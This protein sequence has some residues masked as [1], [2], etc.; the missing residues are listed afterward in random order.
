[1][2]IYNDLT[3]AQKKFVSHV[4][5]WGS[6][7]AA[8][9]VLMVAFYYGS[10]AVKNYQSVRDNGTFPLSVSG[11]GTVYASPDVATVNLTVR[12]QAPLIKDASSDNNKKNNQLVAFL[13]S[14]SVDTK[15]IKT[16]SY[17]VTPQY[18]YDNRPCPLDS[19][20]P[21]PAQLPPKIVGY[22]VSN[23]VEVKVRNLDMVGAILDGAVSAGAN[24]ISGPN[25][26]V[27][28]PD[29]AKDEARAL[30]LNQAKAK[31]ETLAGAM[32]VRLIKISGF[33]ESG[34]TPIY[35]GLGKGMSADIAATPAAPPTIEPGQNEVKVTVVVTYDAK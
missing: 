32:G 14:K 19:R 29:K 13:K 7:G 26:M 23:S 4:F 20:V 31:A 12:T 22:E 11:E 33:S 15:D 25:F 27:D 6:L 5:V 18:Q 10:S 35:Y 28:D 8:L 24:E 30:A 3:L 1:M 21:C 17:N 9:L 2:N 34:G 16:T